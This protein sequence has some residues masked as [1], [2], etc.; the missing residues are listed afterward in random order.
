MHYIPVQGI[1]VNRHHSILF[2][3]N[4]SRSL[5]HVFIL[6][7]LALS[8]LQNRAEIRKKIFLEILAEFLAI[9][10]LNFQGQKV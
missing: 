4:N 1:T 6:K 3:I 2:D 9:T 10:V 8:F 5:I 7:D